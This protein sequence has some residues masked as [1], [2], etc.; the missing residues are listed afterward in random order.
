VASVNNYWRGRLGI[1]ALGLLKSREYMNG[2]TVE[3]SYGESETL[4]NILTMAF[5][6]VDESV[7]GISSSTA[8]R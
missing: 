7:N 5:A 3:S 1:P 8:K 2:L 4:K 6:P